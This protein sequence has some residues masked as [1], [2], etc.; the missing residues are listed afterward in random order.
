MSMGTVLWTGWI[1]I[2]V[3]EGNYRPVIKIVNV[4]GELVP[5]YEWI[6][7]V[8]SMYTKKETENE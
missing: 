8:H 1:E 2:R 6:S 4:S 7:Q 5:L 3:I